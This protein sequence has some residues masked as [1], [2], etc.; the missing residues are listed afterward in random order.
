MSEIRYVN[1]LKR[2]WKQ[3][4]CVTD[5]LL[6]AD[7]YACAS[8]DRYVC[9]YMYIVN[10]YVYIVICVCARYDMFSLLCKEFV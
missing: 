5:N 4:E 3:W 1:A 6:L 9:I 10:V 2:C 8:S 7:V